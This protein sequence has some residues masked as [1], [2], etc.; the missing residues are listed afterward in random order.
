MLDPFS[1][2]L[3]STMGSLLVSVVANACKYQHQHRRKMARFTEEQ[4]ELKRQRKY[5]DLLK[6]Y[7]ELRLPFDEDGI[8]IL[9]IEWC[10]HFCRW[11]TDRPGPVM[12]AYKY[13]PPYTTVGNTW[14]RQEQ[15]LIEDIHP[16]EDANARHERMLR[17]KAIAYLRH[18]H[19]V[20]RADTD[21]VNVEAWGQGTVRKIYR[22][23][24]ADDCRCF[25]CI[26]NK[27]VD[28]RIIDGVYCEDG[29]P[30]LEH[31]YSHYCNCVDCLRRRRDDR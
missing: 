20:V 23:E 28:K 27:V 31:S 8:P 24:F 22:H 29:H 18:N 19:E 12:P 2:G 6:E 26:S 25:Q 10:G 9:P 15:V 14:P 5:D 7:P 17:E 11:T 4:N 1:I 16:R 13:Y 21:Y 30:I 3:I